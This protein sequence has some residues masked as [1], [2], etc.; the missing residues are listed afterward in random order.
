MANKTKVSKTSKGERRSVSWKSHRSDR[1][2]LTNHKNKYDAFLKGRKVYF[3]IDNPNPN[4]TMS[5][6]IRVEGKVL[7]GDYR[8]AKSFPT[9]K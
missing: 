7:Y 1:D 4:Q 5:R 6:K 8:K 3:T 9:L 2:E